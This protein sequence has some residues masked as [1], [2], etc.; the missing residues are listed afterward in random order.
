[1][2][3]E[4]RPNLVA[5]VFKQRLVTFIHDIIMGKQ[6]CTREAHMAVVDL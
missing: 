3:S 6:L 4:D 2:T 1:M 5:R